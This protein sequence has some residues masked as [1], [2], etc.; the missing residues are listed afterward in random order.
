MS[1]V[2]SRAAVPMHKLHAHGTLW[3]GVHD[4]CHAGMGCLHVHVHERTSQFGGS[5]ANYNPN[6]ACPFCGTD[7][8]LLS[9]LLFDCPA[10]SAQRISMF[11]KVSSL[12]GCAENC[13][14]FRP[15]LLH[16]PRC[17][18]S[19]SDDVWGGS[20]TGQMGSRHVSG[21]LVQAWALQSTCKHN[22]GAKLPLPPAAVGRGAGGVVAM[23]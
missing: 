18:N 5:R 20:G 6:I 1:S 15:C 3:A 14:V 17:C 22:D 10:T 13:A 8:E 23:A 2:V 7:V 16:P 21:Y 4:L 11:D 9:R 19:V 12:T